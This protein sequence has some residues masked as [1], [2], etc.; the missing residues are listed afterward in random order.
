MP[1]CRACR[2]FGGRPFGLYR[3]GMTAEQERMEEADLTEAWSLITE[4]GYYFW[5]CNPLLEYCGAEALFT[6][7]KGGVSTGPWQGLNLSPKTGDHPELVNTNLQALMTALEIDPQTV[8]GVKQ[9]HGVEIVNP[10]SDSYPAVAPGADGLFDREGRHVLVTQHADCAPVYLAAIGTPALMLVHAGWRGSAAG[11]TRQ[12]VA[13]FMQETDCAA[14]DIFAA[15]GPCI[16]ECCYEV[17]TEVAKAF[18]NCLGERYAEALQVTPEKGT[19]GT[20]PALTP[21]PEAA[22]SYRLNLAHANRVI[23]EQTG[24][25]P[26]HIFESHLCTACHDEYFYSHRRDGGKTGRMLA[27]LRR[28]GVS[29]R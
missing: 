1:S 25:L 8:R 2:R 5:R 18:A 9:V 28:T 7:R 4:N 15:I 22:Y 3:Q 6:T 14:K 23:L 29:A 16:H 12:G 17:G 19:E 20:G 10:G 27:I 13:R 24:I 21:E 26:E 11:I